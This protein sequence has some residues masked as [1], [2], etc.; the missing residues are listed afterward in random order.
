MT[1]ASLLI[2]TPTLYLNFSGDQLTG[3][4]GVGLAF[5]DGHDIGSVARSLYLSRALSLTLAVARAR[6]PPPH[7][8]SLSA[9]S[10]HLP[11]CLPAF[12]FLS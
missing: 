6:S 3:D 9:R 8:P 10:W 2:A 7:T 5:S 12:R 4:V 1:Q 11:P